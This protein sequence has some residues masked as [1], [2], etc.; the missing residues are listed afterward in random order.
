M[1]Y[2]AFLKDTINDNKNHM[3]FYLQ[4]K[5]EKILASTKTQLTKLWVNGSVEGYSQCTNTENE[6]ERQ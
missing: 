1:L 2:T 3:I 5:R 6:K 4:K